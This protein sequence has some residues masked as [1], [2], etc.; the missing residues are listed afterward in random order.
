ML[1]TSP[2]TVLEVVKNARAI[3]RTV[4]EI[5]RSET[6]A[7]AEFSGTKQRSPFRRRERRSVHRWSVKIPVTIF[8]VMSLGRRMKQLDEVIAVGLARDISPRGIGLSYDQPMRSQFV[9][10]E[11]DLFGQGTR[12]LLTEL[13]W[14]KH[15]DEY[16]FHGGGK[17]L[18]VVKEAH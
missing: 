2:D 10:V 18:G 13:R 5:L 8:S 1:T 6:A 3:S 12:Q 16:E 7:M 4:S 11:F 14:V 17:F 9:I 15:C